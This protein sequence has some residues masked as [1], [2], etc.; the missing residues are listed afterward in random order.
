MLNWIST[1]HWS[2]NELPMELESEAHGYWV[3]LFLNSTGR[4][5]SWFEQPE[6]IKDTIRNLYADQ[7]GQWARN[8]RL[9]KINRELRNFH[10]S[11]RHRKKIYRSEF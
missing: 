6:H 11:E 9:R 10:Y 4:R 2:R 5:P 7:N 8:Y 1:Q 3:R